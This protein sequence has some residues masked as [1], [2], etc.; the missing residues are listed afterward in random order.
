M[1]GSD[2]HGGRAAFI[3]IEAACATGSLWWKSKDGVGSEAPRCR[4]LVV[5]AGRLKSNHSR[6]TLFRARQMIA[7][8]RRRATTCVYI[9]VTRRV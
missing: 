3:F 1:L 6:P 9:V 8:E 2:G 7:K 5:L 4:H